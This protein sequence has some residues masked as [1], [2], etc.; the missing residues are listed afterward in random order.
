MP[1]DLQRHIEEECPKECVPCPR[2][3]QIKYR[4]EIEDHLDGLRKMADEEQEHPRLAEEMREQIRGFEYGLCL[5]GPEQGIE[6]ISEAPEYYN[7]RRLSLR[8][9]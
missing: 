5:L 7:G 6:S 3:K 9:R 8:V 2:C 4:N 1:S